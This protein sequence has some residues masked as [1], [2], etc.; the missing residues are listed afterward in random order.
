MIQ[1]KKKIIAGVSNAARA[2]AAM[3][4]LSLVGIGSFAIDFPI[5]LPAFIATFSAEAGGFSGCFI[6]EVIFAFSHRRP[7]LLHRIC[8]RHRR[9]DRRLADRRYRG[10]YLGHLRSR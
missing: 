4:S 2:K 3:I 10:W 5:V 8:Y 1:A 6:F 7:H 9:V